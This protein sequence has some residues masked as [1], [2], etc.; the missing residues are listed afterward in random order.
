MQSGTKTGIFHSN[1]TATQTYNKQL[2]Q[3]CYVKCKYN[4]RS[5]QIKMKTVKMIPY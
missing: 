1:Q 2:P 5:Y 3:V 4:S